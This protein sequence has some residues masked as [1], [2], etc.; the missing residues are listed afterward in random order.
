MWAQ[1]AG[2]TTCA[3]AL[4][5]RQLLAI[6]RNYLLADLP[7]AEWELIEPQLIAHP[8][9]L[10]QIVLLRNQP[11]TDVWFIEQGV[12][13]LTADI[14]D[15]AIEV[16]V[17][18]VGYEGAVGIPAILGTRMSSLQQGYAQVQGSAVRLPSDV[19]LD[20]LS[21][22]PVF[23][24]RCHIYLNTLFNQ[25]AQL[26][27]CNLRHTVPERLARWLLTTRDRLQDD[28][29]PLTQEFLGIM[30]GVRRP[31]VS[32]AAQTLQEAGVI[33]QERGRI[34]VL[35]AD[36]LAKIACSCYGKVKAFYPGDLW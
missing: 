32:L 8:L 16:E 31:G 7:S 4:G 11:I 1:A 15:T 26:A 5:G 10:R 20:L 29:L 22:C 14:N 21:S 18:V 17:G 13:S 25:T 30:L 6:S 24:S 12:V 35:D 3:P 23:A 27:A 9:A 33:R 36:G 2:E 19:V 28:T 34:V